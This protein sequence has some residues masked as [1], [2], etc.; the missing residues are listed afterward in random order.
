MA[1]LLLGDSVAI[2]DLLLLP[3]GR[4]AVS[5]MLAHPEHRLVGLRR[6]QG[7]SYFLGSLE[8]QSRNLDLEITY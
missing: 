2:S 8:G 1:L 3:E 6:R 4:A 7:R 5:L